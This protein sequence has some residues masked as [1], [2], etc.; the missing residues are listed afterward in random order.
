MARSRTLLLL[1]LAVASLGLAQ[2]KPLD[3][4]AYEIWKSVRS[5]TLTNDGKWLMYTV[6]P[7]DGDAVVEI[8]SCDGS[9]SY[10][11]D[12]A[13]PVSF[14]DDC[15]FVVATIIPKSEDTKKARRTKA[16]PEDTPKNGLTI[17][18]LESGQRVD[19]EKVT[20]FSLAPHDKG[21]ILYKP[22]PAKAEPK[23]AEK[24]GEKPEAGKEEAK[25]TEE[26]KKPAVK[27]DHRPGDVWMLRNLATGKE[28]KLENVTATRW[29]K[30]GS[31]FA[32][33]VSTADGSGDGV[34]IFDVQ[35]GAKKTVLAAMGKYPK[36]AISDSTKD[37]AFATDKDDYQAKKP[38][39]SIYVYR[40]ADNKTSKLNTST[41]AKG[42][43]LSDTGS[44]QFSDK[45]DRLIFG[46]IAKAEEEKK[47]D[48]PDD[49]KVSVDVWHWQDPQMM[50]QQLMQAS[51]ER[52]RTYDAICDLTTGTVLQLETPHLRSVFLGAKGESEFA[53]GSTQEPYMKENSWGEGH[54]DYCT[55]DLASGKCAP[56]LTKFNGQASLSP[57][58]KY[59]AGYDEEARDYFCI[60]LKSGKRSSIS[61][62][63]PV[64]IYDEETDTPSN[65]SAYGVAGWTG[66]DDRVLL[67]DHFDI[68]VA[69]PSGSK[70]ATCL[71]GGVGR[72]S[73]IVLRL[74]RLDPEQDF[75]DLSKTQMFAAFNEQAKQA[76]FYKLSNG[77]L[78]RLLM[79]DKGFAPGPAA[80]PMPSLV[81]ARKADVF[82]FQIMDYNKY[83]D[84]CLADAD[85]TNQRTVSNANP[86]QKDYNWYTGELVNWI[87][88]D[89]Q[90]LQGIL[91]KPEN[92]DPTKKYPM[93]TYFYERVSD[94]LH[95][96][97]APAPSASTIN[98]AMYC[99]NGYL[100]FEP[101]IPYKV[102][103]PGESAMSAILPGV[104][105]IVARGY[106]DPKK[107]G[108]QGQSW[109]GYE[110]G[111]LV[112]ETNM[113]AAACAGAPV[114]DM[115]S[116]YG[117]IRWESGV[118][119]EGQY[120]HGQS[121]IGGNLWEN[122]LKFI[123]NSP[124]FF[125]D[126]IKTPLLIMSNDKDGAVPWY[127]G[128]EYYSALRRLN[129]P[130][131]LVCYNEEQHNLVQRKNRKDWSIRMQQFF[132]H[133]LKGAPMPV[134]MAQGIPAM[135]KGKNYGFDLIP[136]TE[137]KGKSDGS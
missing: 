78:S 90:P 33:T 36:L 117:G 13:S 104:Q 6:A 88:N 130:A 48:T 28:E 112:T 22:E 67:Y 61:K 120:E 129:K 69:D 44:F 133:Y 57:N 14:T 35:S 122:P 17:L 32:Y 41:I 19:L 51:S 106:V 8:K 25:K 12:R 39:L 10:T 134:W 1:F 103:Y 136:G 42:F 85:L 111:Y 83:P 24:P 40:A 127:Q 56:L 101:D 110:T 82:A 97:Y 94:G 15:K 98:V 63:I 131:W 126:K 53:L 34:A 84:V 132:D 74:L 47:D 99:S 125:A 21:W 55:I 135:Q 75:V 108:L 58:G 100:V 77:T 52:T 60:D 11:I 76:G 123:E 113:F 95:Q 64:P 49:E 124:I 7:Q 72:S 2:K 93:I 119:R 71:T 16:K 45:G 91:Y 92:F 38:T 26:P 66:G 4:S 73:H 68:W 109:G 46:T 54:S 102:G 65:P 121:R 114:S 89:G 30:D 18:N 59:V 137:L 96:Y 31:E 3:P 50:P 20:S 37:V 115:V 27:A 62:G 118:S 79:V 81:K 86:Q 105:S 43:V 80:S 116:A 128:I 107:L 5:V 23:P 70:P 9:K 87:S 29:A